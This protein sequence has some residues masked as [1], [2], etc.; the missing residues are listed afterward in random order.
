[1]SGINLSRDFIIREKYVRPETPP[2]E[3][4]LNL[5]RRTSTLLT[6]KMIINKTFKLKVPLR[7]LV[8]SVQKG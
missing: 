2:A 7:T 4:N 5:M 3:S 6:I 8:V 1:M